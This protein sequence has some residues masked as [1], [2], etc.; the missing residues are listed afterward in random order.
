MLFQF[1]WSVAAAE[2]AAPAIIPQPAKMEV[3]A[4]SFPLTPTT[5]ISVNA[6]ARPTGEY[7]AKMLSAAL[8]GEIAVIDQTGE[9]ANA[10]G[11][12]QI[13]VNSALELPTEGYRLDVEPTGVRIFAA[14]PAGAFYGAQT[15]RQLL[16]PSIEVK[17]GDA[18][19]ASALAIPCLHIEDQPRFRWRGLMLDV[20]RHFFTVDEVKRFLNLMA[21]FKF[22]TF[23]WHLTE[24]QGWRIEIQKYPKLTEAAAWRDDGHG[25]KY[26]GF[27]TREQIRDVVAYAAS[28]H[29]SV[30]PEIEMPGHCQAV[31]AAYPELS[32]TGGPFTV[33]TRWGV[34][35]DVYCAG[36][37][38]TFEF[39]ESVLSEAFDL[40]PGETIHIGGDECPKD[41]WKLCPDCQARIKAEGLKD[42]KE[43][44]SYF[45]RRIGAF[46]VS[47]GK[48]I[49]GWDEI[50]E[51][52]L[53]PNAAVMSWHGVSG[54]VAAADADHDVVLSPT[55]H[56]Y[57]DYPQVRP[58][59]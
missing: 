25:G 24:D 52:G 6:A 10:A 29:I 13:E 48:R 42:E 54:A 9:G 34:Y 27:Y 20:G 16:P 28:L 26:G 4:G 30:V 2:P 3:R 37:E 47:K 46:V 57:F 40:F 56:C 1:A 31:L 36:K 45:I 15:L 35:K 14:A 22:N 8:G 23:H 19:Q 59:G 21:L 41:R 32:C 50:L 39:L 58:S 5:K 38:Q 49:I 17:K 51:G 7:L 55:S 33:G 43:L 18:G 12:V 53:A 11:A 44:Q